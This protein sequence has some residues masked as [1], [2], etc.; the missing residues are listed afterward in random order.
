MKGQAL[1]PMKQREERKGTTCQNHR[2][3]ESLVERIGSG[4]LEFAKGSRSSGRAA[5][6]RWD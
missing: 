2:I 1:G 5:Q 6:L 3:K 4:S